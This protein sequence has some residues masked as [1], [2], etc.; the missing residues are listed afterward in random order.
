MSSYQ[1]APA[2]PRRGPSMLNG[3]VIGFFAAVIGAV[4]WA[5]VVGLTHYELGIVA[6]IVG[7]LVGLA[8]ARNAS[9]HPA[10][11]VVAGVL[12][13]FACALGTLLGD[14]ALQADNDEASIMD[15]VEALLSD[16]SQL[17]IVVGNF[18][19]PIDLAFWAFGV[20][21]AYRLVG[22]AV[23][24]AQLEQQQVATTVASPY[25]GTPPEGAA[26]LTP[27][28]PEAAPAPQPKPEAD[29]A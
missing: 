23:A 25:L 22:R 16:P 13:L 12:A 20:I 5:V 9:P 1:A 21:G 24:A 7:A 14:I 19:S 6:A 4:L 11:P 10:L 27:A 26:S 3:V 17:N 28:E 15:T 18:F 2:A 29:P 8:I